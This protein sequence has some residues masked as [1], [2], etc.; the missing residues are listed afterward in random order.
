[1]YKA[2]STLLKNTATLVSE[3]QVLSKIWGK[4]A[5]LQKHRDLCIQSR[6]FHPI[7]IKNNKYNIH[8][9]NIKKKQ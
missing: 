7:S 3:V 2:Y 6:G 4:L 1:M 9:K 8:N 5:T